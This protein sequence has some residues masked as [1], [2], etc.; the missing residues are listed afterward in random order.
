MHFYVNNSVAVESYKQYSSVLAA[1]TQTGSKIEN[2]LISTAGYSPDDDG[3]V[4]KTL[5]AKTDVDETY[6][7]GFGWKKGANVNA[8]DCYDEIGTWISDKQPKFTV[9][10]E[11]TVEQI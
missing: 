5:A 1:A 4:Y 2:S 8:T 10:Y 3:G 9:T 11:I 6:N 7:F